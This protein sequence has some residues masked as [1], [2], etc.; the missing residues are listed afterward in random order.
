MMIRSRIIVLLISL[1]LLLTACGQEAEEPSGPPKLPEDTESLELL[2]KFDLSLRIGVDV[3]DIDT[4]SIEETLFDD[5]SLDVPQAGAQYE[6]EITPGY[7][8]ILEVDGESY[9]YH[10]SADIVVYAPEPE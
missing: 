7:I 10:A 6:P 9:Q 2:A 4:K 8:I 3:E 1:T 5:A